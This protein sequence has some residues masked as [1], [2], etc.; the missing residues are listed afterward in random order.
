VTNGR[1]NLDVG[2]KF[3]V[4]FDQM[5][6]LEVAI[7]SVRSDGTELISKVGYVTGNGS[8]EKTAF[9]RSG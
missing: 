7:S 5:S 1:R 8:G 9:I 4:L 6:A 3:I 2:T